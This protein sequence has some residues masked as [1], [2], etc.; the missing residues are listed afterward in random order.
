[1]PLLMLR[2]DDTCNDPVWLDGSKVGTCPWPSG[3]GFSLSSGVLC[4]GVIASGSPGREGVC[5]CVHVFVPDTPSLGAP[6]EALRSLPGILWSLRKASAHSVDEHEIVQVF[7]FSM[8]L[9]LLCEAMSTQ[10]GLPE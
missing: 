8:N 9:G 6:R 3:L 10:R 2:N 7:V 4:A 1:M 5:L